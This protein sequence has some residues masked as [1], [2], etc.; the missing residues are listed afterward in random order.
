MSSIKLSRI[1][2]KSKTSGPVITG[3]TTFTGTQSARLPSGDNSERVGIES[4]SLRYNDTAGL[5]EF[6]DGET[7]NFIIPAEESAN[8]L[9]VFGGGFDLSYVQTSSIDYLTISTLG[10]VN[11]FG[12]LSLTRAMYGNGC[13]SSTR[14]V[15]GGGYILGTPANIRINTI[16]YITISTTGN[17]SDFGDLTQAKSFIGGCSNSTRGVFGGG[18]NNTPTA[19]FFN[20]IE[21]ITIATTGNALDFGDLTVARSLPASCSSS[22]RGVFGGGNLGPAISNV[23]NYITIATKS[24]ALVFGDLSIAR[25]D[26]AGCSSSTRGIIAGGK[27]DNAGT[28]QYPIIEYITIATTGNAQDFGDLTQS[29]PSS[30]CSSSTRGILGMG[31]Y[32]YLTIAT[33]GNSVRFETPSSRIS[34][35]CQAFSNNHGGLL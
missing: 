1:S 3:I 2:N 9:G 20:T 11:Q 35:G 32:D 28:I 23:I 8:A 16:D 17:A 31:Y 5:L 34:Y 33:L 21:Y 10:D 27:N 22:T 18:F 13:S 26:I 24:N 29:T 6:Y 30:G 19:T 25:R 15:F 12:N 7:W 14:G 4:G